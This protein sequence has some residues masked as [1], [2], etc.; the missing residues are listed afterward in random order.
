MSL[1]DGV[2]S[3]PEA[4]A[5]IA[6]L[7]V[8]EGDSAG[9]RLSLQGPSFLI[10]LSPE[11][12]HR[13]RDYSVA[14][15]HCEVLVKETHL[16]VRDLGSPVGTTLN[17]LRMT[18][19]CLAKV[20]QG[21][22]IRVGRSVFEV[23]IGESQALEHEGATTVAAQRL[24]QQRLGPPCQL[25]ARE[26]DLVHSRD[27]AGI[28]VHRI[29]LPRITD[30]TATQTWRRILRGLLDRPGPGRLVLDLRPVLECS[31]EAVDVLL[32][33][34]K[35]LTASGSAVKVCDVRPAVIQVLKEA[36]IDRLICAALDPTDAVWSQW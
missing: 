29:D 15:K 23:M 31:V 2:R 5:V 10:G 25:S 12:Q 35:R 6:Q 14:E 24:L 33:F 8:V 20:R 13:P 11:C 4:N 7:R 34:Q 22:R 16:A 19:D 17:G 3:R 18:P 36:D 32:A 9:A 1:S 28:P 30:G 26:R 21:D 27:L